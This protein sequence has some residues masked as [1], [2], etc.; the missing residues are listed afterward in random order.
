MN[1]SGVGNTLPSV[2]VSHEKQGH[3][4]MYSQEA[5]QLFTAYIKLTFLIFGIPPPNQ[6]N[7]VF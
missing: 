5:R 6:S 1:L 3:L 7:A 4:C 2:R